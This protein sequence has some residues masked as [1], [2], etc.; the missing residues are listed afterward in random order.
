[1][2]T[3]DEGSS[4]EKELKRAELKAM[5]L[6]QLRDRSE[7]ELRDKLIAKEFSEETIEE[8]VK[9]LYAHHYLDD[10]RLCKSFIRVR[11]GAYSKKEL[12]HKLSERGIQKQ[13]IEEAFEELE[14]EESEVPSEAD[15]AVKLVQKKLKGRTSISY[16]EKQKLLAAL[17]RKGFSRSSIDAAL[18]D[19]SAGPEEYDY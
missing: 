19:I 7:K 10:L 2:K 11:A 4:E 1:M 15:A 5:E 12:A 13:V 9:F 16:E 8:T 6:L 17:Y 3:W 18:K 14:E